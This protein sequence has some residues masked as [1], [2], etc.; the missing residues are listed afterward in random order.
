MAPRRR[1]PRET[2]NQPQVEPAA[3]LD[4]LRQSIER[5][6][7]LLEE[8]PVDKDAYEA[9][10]LLTRNFLQRAFGENS[11]NVS[12]VTDV[13]KFGSFPMGAGEEW[14]EPHRAESLSTQLTKLESLVELLETEIQ[15]QGGGVIVAPEPERRGHRIFLVHG[16]DEGALHTVA[17]FLEGLE[18]E[19]LILR[20]QPNEGRT[21]IE[22][23]EDYAD[24]GFA[25]VLLTPDDRGGIA[26]AAYEDQ[27]PRAR[28]NVV[29]ELG[30]FLGYLGRRR[31]CALHR[32]GVEIPSDYDGVLYL[33]LDEEGA[34]RLKLAKE[35][36]AAG[37]TV[38]M[39]K[40]T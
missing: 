10:E 17:R 26:G 34:W 25:I 19:V 7:S 20:E 39:N 27:Q 13:G 6:R 2:W 21:I 9:W 37:L 3:G 30:F 23:F 14:W 24:V 33:P 11:P 1:S 35:L 5:G 31:V 18:Q 40:A 32:A 16:H 22:K 12:A 29:L 28:Q 8:R 36:K 15:L 4:L 38:D